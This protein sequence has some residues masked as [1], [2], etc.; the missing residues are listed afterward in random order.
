MYLIYKN[1]LTDKG[2]FLFSCQTAWMWEVKS[3]I[4]EEEP[5]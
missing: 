3:V 4:N 1:I 5:S 2:L